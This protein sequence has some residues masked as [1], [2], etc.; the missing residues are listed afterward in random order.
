M[1]SRASP[2]LGVPDSV[3]E[4]VA[5]RLARLAP[6]ARALVGARRHRRPAH[7]AAGAVTRR[8]VHRGEVAEP[9]TSSS[10][11]GCS[12]TPAGC[13][14]TYQFPH[15]LVR[16][17]V[18]DTVSPMGRARLHLRVA[19]GDRGR[20]TRRTVGAC[21]RSWRAT[22]PPRASL[23]GTDKA[24]YYGRRAGAQAM[25]SA[26]FDLAISHLSTAIVL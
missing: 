1:A 26:A 23:G 5:A 11:P 22:S 9:S 3:K 24:V 16:E 15:A 13:V 8:G 17:S 18:A 12:P 21:S 7:R 4:V 2:P 10:T 25:R 19:G 20:S 6:L 14:L